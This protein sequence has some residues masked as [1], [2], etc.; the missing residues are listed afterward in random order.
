[1]YTGISSFFFLGV[2]SDF[3]DFT[4]SNRLGCLK[5]NGHSLLFILGVFQKELIITC[6]EPVNY[7][8]TYLAPQVLCA[9]TYKW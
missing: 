7:L 4:M 3:T 8:K 5:K 2:P 9:L 1:M 6:W